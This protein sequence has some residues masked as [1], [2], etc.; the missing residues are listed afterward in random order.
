MSSASAR[1]PRACIDCEAPRV[2]ARQRCNPCYARHKR[3]LK[4]AGEYTPLRTYGSTTERLLAD[5]TPGWGGC[6]LRTAGID[7]DGYGLIREGAGKT[8]RAHRVAYELLVGPI[9]DGLHLD[10][11]C[12]TTD[13]SCAGGPSCLHRRCINPRHLEPVTSAE[14]SLRGVNAR[15]THCSN[16]HEFTEANTRIDRGRRV[17]RACDRESSRRYQARR[18]AAA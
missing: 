6:I 8:R 14:N 4:R 17:C 2:Y 9:P 12:H 11:L 10:H 7:R 13:T 16:G 15:K 18:K 3:A 1:A 5:V